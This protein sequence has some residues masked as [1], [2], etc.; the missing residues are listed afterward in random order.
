VSKSKDFDPQA[1]SNLMWAFAKLGVSPDTA[2]AE[3][4]SVEAVSRN[5]D[6]K[7]QEI[8]NLMWAFA[9]AKVQPDAALVEA[10]SVEA[11][12]RSK[13]FD[14]Q[15]ISNLMWAFATL[16]VRPDAALVEAMFN[17]LSAGDVDTELDVE[18]KM[19]LHQFFLFNSLLPDPSDVSSLSDLAAECKAAFIASSSTDT[20]TSALQHHVTHALRRLVSEDVLEE[21]VLE[22]SGFSVDMRLAGTRVVVEVDG[23]THYLRDAAVEVGQGWVVDGS[24]QFKHRTLTKLGWTVLQ[25]PYFEWNAL[26][27]AQEQD[28]YLTTLLASKGISAGGKE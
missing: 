18:H 5:K 13:D 26:N 10:M 19:Q 2:L 4:M 20:H 15:A 25:V 16:G 17:K 24:T 22:D 28:R 9:T 11:M 1:M 7:P 27:G 21:Q 6:F 23:P 8:A 3:A 12:S 14:P